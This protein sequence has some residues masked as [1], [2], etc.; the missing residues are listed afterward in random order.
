M[1][2]MLEEVVDGLSPRYDELMARAARRCGRRVAVRRAA[3]VRT[4][5]RRARMAHRA[6]PGAARSGVRRIRRR[7]QV[8]ARLAACASRLRGTRSRGDERLEALITRTLDAMAWGGIFDEVDGGFFRYAA[9][10]DW[11]RPHTEKMLEDQAAMVGLL[12][13]GSLACDRA[14]WRERAARRDAVR[15]AHALRRRPGRLLREPA[16]RRGVLRGERVDPR[17]AR[18]AGRGPHVV[19]RRER[20]GRGRVAARGRG[21]RRHRRSGASRC[22]RS[23]AS[24]WPPTSPARA[25]RTFHDAAGE[26]RGLLSDQVHAA[27]ALLH[28]HDATGDETYLMLAEELARTALRTHWDGHGGGF[29]DHAPGGADDIGLLRDPVKP[30][31][32]NCLAARVL[33]AARNADGPRRA[34]G[35]RARGPRVADWRLSLARHRRRALRAR[36][37]GRARALTQ[38]ERLEAGACRGI[39]RMHGRQPPEP[40]ARTAAPAPTSASPQPVAGVLDSPFWRFARA[41]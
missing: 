26:V 5:P 25:W 28:V 14:S 32:L 15:A 23:N 38:P 12:V 21:A 31:A 2:R 34:A 22:S 33:V 24:C 19:H 35:A 7:R 17:D 1:A 8:P 18:S 3:A 41:V 27:W 37:H 40:A 29:L 11:T 16:R 10:R 6:D 20:A 30:L 39:A 4:R 36:D 9:G 13:D